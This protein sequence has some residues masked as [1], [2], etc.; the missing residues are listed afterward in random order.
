[1]SAEHYN[2]HVCKS[3]RQTLWTRGHN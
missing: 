2:I 3:V 1:V